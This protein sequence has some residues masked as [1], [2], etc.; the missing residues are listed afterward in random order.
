[1]DKNNRILVIGSINMGISMHIKKIPDPWETQ[2]AS[3]TL[4]ETDG[5]ASRIA[6]AAARLGASTS[7]IGKIGGD[8]YGTKVMQTLNQAGIDTQHVGI[9]D[10]AYTGIVILMRTDKKQ[11]SVVNSPGANVKFTEGE[12]AKL[13]SFIAKHKIIVLTNKVPLCA[14][15]EALQIAKKY[16]LLVIFDPS[17]VSEVPPDIYADVDILLPNESDIKYTAGSDS[18]DL[19][20]SRLALSRYMEMGVKKAAILKIGADGVL[21]KSRNEFITLGSVDMVE[22]EIDL[23]GDKDIFTAALAVAL[24][25]NQKLYQSSIYAKAAAQ[26]SNMESGVRAT[27]PTKEALQAYLNENSLFQEITFYNRL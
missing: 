12:I 27:V 16:N 7:I 23:K 3:S 26:L 10:D 24:S 19:K 17:P 11:T 13:E 9:I 25:Q 15:H 4:F 14:T 1:M 18:I 6:T 8:S 22:D 2:E 5:K 21:I 20:C